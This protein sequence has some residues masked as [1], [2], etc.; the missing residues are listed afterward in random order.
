MKI[1]KKVVMIIFLVVL[2]L[3][4]IWMIKDFDEKIARYEVIDKNEEVKIK[5]KYS[6][7]RGTDLFENYEY[8]SAYKKDIFGNIKESLYI[9]LNE[10]EYYSASSK[11]NWEQPKFYQNRAATY[12]ISKGKEGYIDWNGNKTSEFIYDDTNNYEN[13]YAKVGIYKG[14]ELK[15]GVIDLD[16]NQ[17]VPCIY[18]D[19]Y[20]DLSE[21]DSFLVQEKDSKYLINKDNSKIAEYIGDYTLKFVDLNELTNIGEIDTENVYFSK[22]YILIYG[23]N[24]KYG[25]FTKEGNKISDFIYD[26]FESIS[27]Q[28][29]FLVEEAGKRYVIDDKLNIIFNAEVIEKNGI[30]MD[31]IENGRIK[32]KKNNKYGI[33]DFKGNIIIEPEYDNLSIKTAE[34]GYFSVEKN[35]MYGV[36]DLN[37]NE[38]IKCSKKYKTDFIGNGKY[39]VV[40]KN[41][42]KLVL[43]WG[44]LICITVIIEIVILKRFF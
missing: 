21:Y 34:K 12:S 29:L 5:P 36:I 9:D 33:A 2:V 41:D 1:V 35:N 6:F 8:M 22:D 30:V 26:N 40:Q 23:N 27:S 3:L 16:G 18:E 37:G 4:D 14:K 15:Y 38:I 44:L 10:N 25:I 42:F 20:M 28:Y 43:L 11:N 31:S 13:G 24:G 17:I 39:F 32:I 7:I 19:I